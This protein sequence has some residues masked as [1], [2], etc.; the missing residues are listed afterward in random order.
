MLFLLLRIRGTAL[1]YKYTETR[2]HMS[3]AGHHEIDAAALPYVLPRV[4]DHIAK[5]Y[6]N[7]PPTPIRCRSTLRPIH[8]TP[9]DFK[10]MESK[11][12][13]IAAP[14][15]SAKNSPRTETASHKSPRTGHGNSLLMS[16]YKRDFEI[17]EEINR[18]AFND[19]HA[20]RVNKGAFE[21]SQTT[22]LFGHAYSSTNIP[23]PPPVDGNA[24]ASIVPSISTPRPTTVSPAP[25]PRKT[26]ADRIIAQAEIEEQHLLASIAASK[27]EHE[28]LRTSPRRE[29]TIDIAKLRNLFLESVPQSGASPRRRVLMW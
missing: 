10:E 11:S 8:L 23:T 26:Y 28:A 2:T 29:A 19:P 18:G 22:H 15:T 6:H 13:I 16:S 4:G 3:A 20:H 9:S 25:S 12:H 24:R 14:V 17:P 5:L 21:S 1:C 7:K 27:R